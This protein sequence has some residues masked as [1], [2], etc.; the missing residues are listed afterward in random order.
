MRSLALDPSQPVRGCPPLD[1]EHRG[2]LVE[3]GVHD[4]GDIG[5]DAVAVRS[6]DERSRRDCPTGDLRL[7]RPLCLRALDGVDRGAVQGES[8]IATEIR[9]L[10]RVRH[11]AKNQFAILE[12]RLDPGDPRRPV[13]SQ[14]RN[15]LVSVSIKQRPHAPRELR[16]CL[17]DVLPCRHTAM[18]APM[19]D[20]PLARARI[21][22]IGI[23]RNSAVLA[24]AFVAMRSRRPQA[25]HE[26]SPSI[27]IVRRR[28]LRTHLLNDCERPQGPR[29][30]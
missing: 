26:C 14:G 17:F 13:G 3:V 4:L 9:S 27:A 20:S 11:R 10:A 28:L 29:H 19:T 25:T 5:V 18:F 24:I 1:D 7:A 15:C 12:D 2:L 22:A 16:L 8:R 21:V 30:R 23:V 6:F